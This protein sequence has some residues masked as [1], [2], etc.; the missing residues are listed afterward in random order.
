MHIT[1]DVDL[2]EQVL[3]AHRRG[4]LVLFVG[5]GVSTGAPSKLPLFEGLAKQLARRAAHPFSKQRGLDF[6]VG[7]LESLPGGFDAHRHAIEIIGNPKST[8]NSVH[9]ALIELADAG[10]EFRIV[11]TNYDRHLTTAAIESGITVPDTWYGPALPLGGQFRG[12]VYLHGSVDRP[13]SEMVLTDRDFGHAY[14]TEAW[15]TRFL[16]PMFDKFTVLFIGYS[17]DDVIMRYLALGLPSRDED[18]PS[19]RFALTS[20]AADPK[21]QYLDI[22]PIRY[23]SAVGNH[24]NLLIALQKWNERARMGQLDHP[25]HV[26]EVVSGGVKLQ[27]VDRDYLAQRIRTAEGARDFITAVSSQEVSS[28]A[29]WL[30]WM[31]ELAEFRALFDGALPSDHR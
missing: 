12:L 14:L 19:R 23:T 24:G 13:D 8:F 25:A 3:E 7:S 6:F 17:H 1:E 18:T 22:T 4:E 16:I 2:P 27:P 20:T 5:A 15:A 30:R 21:W 26:H 29:D 11:V 10:G 9:T 31:E 28:Q